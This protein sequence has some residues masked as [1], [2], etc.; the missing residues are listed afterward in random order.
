[1]IIIKKVLLYHVRTGANVK[2]V[3]HPVMAMLNCLQATSGRGRGHHCSRMIWRMKV[4]KGGGVGRG[5]Q[6]IITDVG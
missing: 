1:M 2:S 3:L 4:S 6:S 5:L